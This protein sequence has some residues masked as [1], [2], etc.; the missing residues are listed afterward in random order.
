LFTHAR[1]TATT[2]STPT[3]T[4][5]KKQVTR[6]RIRQIEAKA[7]RKLRARTNQ[8][9]LEDVMDEYAME[10]GR[11]LAREGSGAGKAG[12]RVAGGSKKAS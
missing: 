2:K 1:K 8:G 11:A 4:T 6:E 9:G 5:T 7:L 12:A 10:G 3:T